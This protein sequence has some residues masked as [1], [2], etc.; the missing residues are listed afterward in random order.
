MGC[1]TQ[2]LAEQAPKHTEVWAVD[3]ACI[4]PMFLPRPYQKAYAYRSATA[5]MR[6]ERMAGLPYPAKPHDGEQIYGQHH[7]SKLESQSLPSGLAN[8][9]TV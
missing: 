9:A 1:G 6:R 5:A 7:G 3:T 2:E 4:V 8:I